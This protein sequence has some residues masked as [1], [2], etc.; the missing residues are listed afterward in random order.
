MSC[1][2]IEKSR[3]LAWGGGA[4]EAVSK[5][6]SFDHMGIPSSWWTDL[7]GTT[8]NITFT[9][10]LAGGKYNVLV[11]I[12]VKGFLRKPYVFVFI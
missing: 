12:D 9:P 7:T 5:G 3:G 6:P 10:Q 2:S 8:E 1:G 4:S 11:L